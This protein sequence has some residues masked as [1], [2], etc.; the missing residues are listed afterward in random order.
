[1]IS[2][3][4]AHSQYSV[5]LLIVLFCA[6]CSLSQ[7]VTITPVEPATSSVPENNDWLRVY[8]TDPKAPGASDYEGGP[9]E[10]LAEA[11]DAAR[12]TVDVAI[13][14]LNLWS[15]RNALVDAHNRG[16]V[17][18]VVADS[19]NLGGEEF[20]DLLS[21]CIPVVGDR[22]ESLMHN[23]FVIIDHFEVWTGSM[24]FTVSGAYYDNNNLVRVQSE[25]VAE[26]YLVEFNEMFEE[27]LFGDNILPLTPFPQVT[28]DN[29]MIEVLFSP[30]DG[31]QNRLV[32]L[33]NET[34]SS[35]YFLAYSF[36]ADELGEAIRSRAAAGVEVAGVMEAEQVLSNEGTE[37]DRFI[38]TG[39]DVR[40]DGNEDQMH[41]KVIIIDGRIVITGSYNFSS[42]AEESNDENVLILHDDKAASTFTEEFWNI[43]NEAQQP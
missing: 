7:P 43:Y 6:G 18:R 22:R 2:R 41:D 28:I 31:V 37:Y 10:A 20:Q 1:L 15:I 19:D 35:I 12:L 5:F 17:V 39:L 21:A 36:T 24:N 14:S 3:R 9:D 32:E 34:Q 42:S 4:I 25:E 38:Q 29:F 13:Y 30:D 23:K 16:V 27:D 8:F 26:D 40:L 33:L 11:I